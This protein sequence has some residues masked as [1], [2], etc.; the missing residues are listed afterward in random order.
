MGIKRHAHQKMFA[1]VAQGY[2]TG[3]ARRDTGSSG[4]IAQEDWCLK[5]QCS[6]TAKTAALATDD[7]C[8]ALLRKRTPPVQAGHRY[9]NLHSNPGAAARCFGRQYFHVADSGARSTPPPT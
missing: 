6:R 4:Q 9:R 2:A 5:L 1:V 7:E 8:H 3:D